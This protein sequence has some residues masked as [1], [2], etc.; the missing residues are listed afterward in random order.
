MADPLAKLLVTSVSRL[1]CGSPI[2]AFP[3]AAAFGGNHGA[4]VVDG[5]P[6]GEDRCTML[7]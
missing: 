5:V 4:G 7:A 1:P 3:T 6:E 2:S